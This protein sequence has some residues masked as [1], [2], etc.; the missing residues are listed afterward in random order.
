M[1]EIRKALMFN[2]GLQEDKKKK[3][4]VHKYSLHVHIIGGFKAG[5][6]GATSPQ[7]PEKNER[8]A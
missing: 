8:M 5:G 6:M 3:A 1:S 7:R 4:T 2:A